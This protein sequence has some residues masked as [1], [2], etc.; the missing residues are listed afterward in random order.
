MMYEGGYTQLQLLIIFGLVFFSE[1][2]AWKVR[3]E[4]KMFSL[5]TSEHELPV[6][7]KERITVDRVESP[8]TL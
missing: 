6:P 8:K 2:T 7:D 1:L 3:S 5:P 4:R